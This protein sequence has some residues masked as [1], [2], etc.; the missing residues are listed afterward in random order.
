MIISSYSCQG[1]CGAGCTGTAI[2]NAYTQDCWNH[3]VCSWFNSGGARL[4]LPFALHYRGC[5]TA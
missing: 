4:V 2:G 1:R 5:L 3:D